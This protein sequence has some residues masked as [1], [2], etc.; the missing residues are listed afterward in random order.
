VAG[1]KIPQKGDSV[2]RLARRLGMS[3]GF[4]RPYSSE[5]PISIVLRPAV[6]T[7]EDFKIIFSILGINLLQ[8]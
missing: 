5:T 6:S 2:G 3:I 4:G 1:Y 7:E 8:S